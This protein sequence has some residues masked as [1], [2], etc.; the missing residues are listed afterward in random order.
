[1]PPILAAAP[2]PTAER[3]VFPTGL[4]DGRPDLGHNPLHSIAA[5][6]AIA[7]NGQTLL[8]RRSWLPKAD[9]CRTS[10]IQ[11][12]QARSFKDYSYVVSRLS[13]DVSLQILVEG[14]LITLNVSVSAD[15]YP[16][17]RPKEVWDPFKA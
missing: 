2:N 8:C 5:N 7:V 17:P 6:G 13:L 9:S 15:A 16:S 10:S 14:V 4:S 12:D 11:F 3:P 1:M